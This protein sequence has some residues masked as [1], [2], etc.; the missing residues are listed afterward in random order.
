M[1]NIFSFL[2]GLVTCLG[3]CGGVRAE[4]AR[5]NAK[6]FD[7]DQVRLLDGPF[8]AA[9]E[10]D[11]QYLLSLD[12]E[13][14]LYNFR[15][16]AKLPTSAKPLGGWESPGCGLRGHF[17]GHYLSACAL[18]YAATGD[19]Q[20][21]QRGNYIVAEL[22]KC[23][24]MLMG[25]YLSAFPTRNFD[26]LEAKCGGVWA[27]YYT[28]HKIMAGLLEMHHRC[29]NA[30]ALGIASKMA[31][32]FQERMAKLTPEQIDKVLHT[33]KHG[34]QNEF[35]G[36]SDV[37]HE[38][39]AVTKNPEHLKLANL[40]DQQ[41]I[42]D[43]MANGKDVLEGLHANT[44]IPQ[45]IGWARHYEV[46]G[47]KLYRDAAVFFW[48]QVARHRSYVTGS[49]SESEHFF[50]LGLEA[51]KLTPVTGES[52][53]VYNMLKLTR[54]LMLWDAQAEYADF[55]E[56]AVLNHILGSIDP[57]DGMTIY[58]LSLKPG[59]FKVYG[60]PLDAFWCCT[61]TGVENHA[62]YGDAIYFY[63]DNT[64]WVNLFIAS[65]LNWKDKGV[66]LR[67]ETSF[68]KQ[69]GSTFIFKT[70]RPTELTLQIRIPGWAEK[71][72]IKVNGEKQEI[73]VKPRSYAAITRQWKDGDKVELSLPMKLHLH[74]ATDDPTTVAILYGPVVLAGELG[75]ENFP[76]S[77]HSPNHSQ[78]H[79]WPD[80]VVPVLVTDA[81]D[82]NAW[83]KPVEGRPLTFTTVN[84]GKPADIRLSPLYELH[85]QRYSVYWKLMTNSKWKT[86]REK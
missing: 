7:L 9:M 20:F 62:R 3:V 18:M 26:T 84:A 15:T 22:G 13:R 82:L 70:G 74:R 27:P 35:G 83:I 41:W 34:P 49:N 11:R 55:Y 60:T 76:P 75:K 53:N 85:H 67:Q 10:L 65:E 17:V 40:F 50:P 61:G 81:T 45:A 52:C 78:Y 25:G 21:R 59:H 64:L 71:A 1:K 46:T 32:Y 43:A 8:K 14:L 42:V 58:S 29:G 77:D 80:P 33:N 5:L 16:M 12:P 38:L 19:E 31:G 6:A 2:A 36:M 79:K 51:A 54:H 24:Q 44:H 4:T 48:Q 72:G 47:E 57:T 66:T 86:I 69:E 56:R 68:P 30:Q 73:S 28:I 23:Q 37:L 63:N 39:Y